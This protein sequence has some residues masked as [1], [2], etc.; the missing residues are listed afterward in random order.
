[1]EQTKIILVAVVA[2]LFWAAAAFLLACILFKRTFCRWHGRRLL[3]PSICLALALCWPVTLSLLCL[4]ALF[5]PSSSR[6]PRKNQGVD[7]KTSSQSILGHFAR[8]SGYRGSKAGNLSIIWD[9]ETQTWTM[10][11]IFVDRPA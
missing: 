6:V 8:L 11:G 4:A 9:T 3:P 7:N 2:I 1:M 10:A 5:S